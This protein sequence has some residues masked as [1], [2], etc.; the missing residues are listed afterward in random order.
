MQLIWKHIR[1]IKIELNLAQATLDVMGESEYNE[2]GHSPTDKL[3]NRN[4]TNRY[5][6]TTAK[7]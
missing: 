1:H 2:D 7:I 5:S 4:D 3:P 6:T